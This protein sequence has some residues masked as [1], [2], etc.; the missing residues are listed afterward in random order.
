VDDRRW[1]VPRIVES[2]RPT[3]YWTQLNTWLEMEGGLGI[4]K[5]WAKDWLTKNEPV[6]TGDAAPNSTLKRDVIEE[7]LSSGQELV[8]RTL[9]YVKEQLTD[10]NDGKNN[11][12]KDEWEH[13]KYLYNGNVVILDKTLIELIKNQIYQGRQSEYLERPQT[14][15]RIAKMA[16]WTPGSKRAKVKFFG[17][18]YYQ[19]YAICSSGELAQY[20]PSIVF[21][22]MHVVPLPLEVLQDPL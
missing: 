15:R 19:A 11:A 9:N 8:L 21:D 7:G 13:K 20:D 14:V 18:R 12:L 4:I 16:G 5:H 1:F 17:H 3:A 10:I 2:K 6:K 22:Q